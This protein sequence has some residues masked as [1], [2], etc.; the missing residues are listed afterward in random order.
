MQTGVPDTGFLL[1]LDPELGALLRGE[2]EERARRELQ[3]PLRAIGRGTLDPA[4]LLTPCLA[5]VGVLIVS[6]LVVRQTDIHR[7]PSGEL[8][9]PGDL[10]RPSLEEPS[11]GDFE[12]TPHWLALSPRTVSPLGMP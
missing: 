12:G 2:R 1:D 8:L 11:L 9:G 7:E 4:D 6:G 10:I 5:D 3:V